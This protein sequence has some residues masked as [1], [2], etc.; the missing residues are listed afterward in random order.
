MDLSNGQTQQVI[1]AIS[2]DLA[3]LLRLPP[4]AFWQVV[5]SD[6][7]LHTCLDSFLRF[8]RYV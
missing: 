2:A 5:C 1:A 4:A 7:S 8:R 6:T 3:Q